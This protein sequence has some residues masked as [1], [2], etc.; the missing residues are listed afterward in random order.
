MAH[1]LR[2]S[3][4]GCRTAN[5]VTL[6]AVDIGCSSEGVGGKWYGKVGGVQN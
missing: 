4:N 2:T 5:A 6:R 3:S 1:L